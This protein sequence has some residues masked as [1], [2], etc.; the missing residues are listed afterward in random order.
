MTLLRRKCKKRLQSFKKIR[1]LGEMLS[2]N[3]PGKEV[4]LAPLTQ[5]LQKNVSQE[6]QW[7]SSFLQNGATL[8]D[9]HKF[10]DMDWS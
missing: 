5:K 8:E 2:R 9:I 1:F 4:Y 10:K 7:V 6:I 3:Q